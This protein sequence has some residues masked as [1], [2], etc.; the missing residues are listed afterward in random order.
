VGP[1]EVVAVRI[2]VGPREVGDMHREPG[3]GVGSDGGLRGLA[4]ARL[5]DIL[6]ATPTEPYRQLSVPCCRRPSR[7]HI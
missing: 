3:G 4:L 5:D 1:H 2:E 6:R 7:F